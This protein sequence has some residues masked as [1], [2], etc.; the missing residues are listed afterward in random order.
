[1]RKER[2]NGKFAPLLCLNTWLLK[3]LSIKMVIKIT[4]SEWYKEGQEKKY[5]K[6]VYAIMQ[7]LDLHQ[8]AG[9]T[10]LPT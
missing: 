1:M 7:S 8:E 3:Q 9:S 2:K 10:R 5:L 6:L 4:N